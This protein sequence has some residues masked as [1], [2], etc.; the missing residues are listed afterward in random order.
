[1]ERRVVITGIGIYSCIGKNLSEVKESLYHGRSGIIY[2]PERKE[3]GYR[4][5]LTGFVEDPDLKPFLSRRQRIGMHQPAMYAFMSTKEALENAKLDVDFLDKNETGII[6][7]N[8]STA[9]AVAETIDKA[10][11]KKDNTLI[12]SGDIFQ[13][14]NCTVNMNLSTI[15]KLKGINFTLSA[16]CASGSHSIGMGFLMIKQGL[17]ERI[18]CGGAQEINVYTMGS[19]DGLGVFSVRESEPQKASRPFDKDR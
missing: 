14:M 8:D 12:G 18:I 16:A 1:M 13:N 15:Y 2:Q 4:S 11:E 6:F 19:F 5:A 17:Q 9:G 10:R 7:G 3:F